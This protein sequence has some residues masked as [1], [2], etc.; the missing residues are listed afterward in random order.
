MYGFFPRT[1]Q[2]FDTIWV[3]YIIYIGKVPDPNVMCLFL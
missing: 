2:F 3:S 1:K